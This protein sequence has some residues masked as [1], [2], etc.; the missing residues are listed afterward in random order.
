MLARPLP[1]CV[2]Y[3]EGDGEVATV[4]TVAEIREVC[5]R[6]LNTFEVAETRTQA[7]KAL[8]RL[9]IEVPLLLP[10]VATSQQCLLLQRFARYAGASLRRFV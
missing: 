7:T 3:G 10:T 4:G 2:F 9:E 5:R 1:V 6:F 8:T